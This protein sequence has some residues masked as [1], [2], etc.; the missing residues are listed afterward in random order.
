MPPTDIK[1]RVFHQWPSWQIQY[2]LAVA[3]Y[4]RYSFYIVIEYCRRQ[5]EHPVP[6]VFLYRNLGLKC[7][8]I[9]LASITSIYTLQAYTWVPRLQKNQLSHGIGHHILISWSIFRHPGE[10]TIFLKLKFEH[11][12][13]SN[14][15]HFVRRDISIFQ[16]DLILGSFTKIQ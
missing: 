4:H 11:L 14:K 3:R 5:S 13:I 6:C 15:S 9:I 10:T 8:Q 7:P 16:I 2:D 12:K 1:L